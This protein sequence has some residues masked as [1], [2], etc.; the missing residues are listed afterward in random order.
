MSG[1]SAEVRYTRIGRRPGRPA[2]AITRE[3]TRNGGPAITGRTG[4]QA[5]GVT[6][7]GPGLHRVL[8]RSPRPVR[9]APERSQGDGPPAHYRLRH[10]TAVDLVQRL[11]V[12]LAGAA[13][14]MSSKTR[15][16]SGPSSQP[17]RR[18]TPWRSRRSAEPKSSGSWNSGGT[19]WPPGAPG[20]S[21]DPSSSARAHINQIR[22]RHVD[23]LA[24]QSKRR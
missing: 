17:R 12:S 2:P 16:G 21:N 14:A 8:H 11:R 3:V 6:P 1:V 23:L 4:P 9:A 20:E 24:G 18:T 13:N 7:G 19:T 22:P 5:M 15:S 10:L